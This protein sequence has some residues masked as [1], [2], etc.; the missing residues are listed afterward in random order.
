MVRG[1]GL[2]DIDEH[3]EGGETSSATSFSSIMSPLP[4]VIN[5]RQVNGGSDEAQRLRHAREHNSLAD[6]IAPVMESPSISPTTPHQGV[7]IQHGSIS[8]SAHHDAINT[9]ELSFEEEN[10]NHNSTRSSW[11]YQDHQHRMHRDDP[12]HLTPVH[13]EHL[14]ASHVERRRSV[15]ARH[16]P[17]G[18][19]ASLL[20]NSFFAFR[21][22]SSSVV[23]VV[24]ASACVVLHEVTSSMHHW[25][26]NLTDA[27][28][29]ARIVALSTLANA[30]LVVPAL[31]PSYCGLYRVSKARKVIRR[32]FLQ[33]CEI[34]VVGQLVVYIIQVL[35]WAFHMIQEPTCP[36]EVYASTNSV[37]R[38]IIY[39][40][41]WSIL[42]CGLLTW[43]QVTIFC[44]FRTHL[45]LQIGSA[46][47]SRHSAN[48]KGWLKRLFTLPSFGRRNRIIRQLRTD[49]FKAA[50]TG[51]LA[52]AES[53]LTR[54]EQLLGREFA[55]RKLYREP[56]LW[57]WSFATSRKNPLHVAVARGDCAMI[58]LFVKFRFDV[59]ALDKV[60]RVNFNFG[61]FFKWTRLLVK[62][63]DYLQGANEWVFLS[64][65]V[66]PLH[67][68]VQQGQ[69]DAVRTL[70]KHH[71]NVDTLPRASFYWPAAQ[72]NILTCRTAQSTLL[73]ENGSDV[74]LTP[75]HAAAAAN[76][77]VALDALLRLRHVDPDTL[78]EVVAGVHKRTALHWAAISGS[79][80]CAIRLLASRANPEA[81]D[82]DGRTPLHWAARNNHVQVVQVL[83]NQA[84]VNPNVQDNDGAPVLFFAAGAEGVGADVVSAL[85]EA[86]A[87]LAYT[88]M[89]GNTALHIALINENRTTAV[90][91]LRNG[92]DITATNRDGRRAVDCTTSTELQFAVKKEAGARDVMISYTHAHAPVAKGVRDFLVE[93]ARMTCWMDTMDPS[94]IGGGAVWREEIARGIFHAKVVV[95]VVC[96]GYSRS[97]WCLKE[98]AFARL[99]RTPGTLSQRNRLIILVVA[100]VLVVDPHGMSSDVERYVASEYILP[101]ESFDPTN[102]VLPDHV[103]AVIRQAIQTKH[104]PPP[105]LL[106]S[107]LP[108]LSPPPNSTTTSTRSFPNNQQQ[109]HRILSSPDAS[110]TP[111][112][113][114]PMV[115]VCYTTTSDSS[116]Q[117]QLLLR[118]TESLRRRGFVAR[119]AS[120][121]LATLDF[122][123]DV[124]AAWMDAASSVVV[125]LGRQ[126][127]QDMAGLKRLVTRA[128]RCKTA[129]VPVV[130]GGQFLDFS[131][132]YSLSRTSWF[133]FVDGIGFHASFSHLVNQLS[134]ELPHLALAVQDL[135]R[136]RGGHGHTFLRVYNDD[137]AE[138][139]SPSDRPIF[140]VDKLAMI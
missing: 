46:N 118:V 24:V 92:A 96:D 86:G 59:N 49:L 62:T 125:L 110:N 25:C 139:N 134:L 21:L 79:A 115:L 111:N 28:G 33:I 52:L 10:I 122:Q 94:G 3:D 40:K 31:L 83:L 41:L 89:D 68:A 60:A 32:P 57:L 43:W 99:A 44:L 95:A 48:L 51:D 26:T 67:V 8:S 23:L 34:I 30:I 70:L 74:A 78:G 85:V 129:V 103:L 121:S 58:N 6:S 75:L 15:K 106:S 119:L 19:F 140:N 27:T 135:P 4:V 127:H 71:A 82:R 65:L 132:L 120:T 66:P 50:L 20:R 102:P 53:L 124:D 112:D 1:T 35:L 100:V 13:S 137:D 16:A 81:S 108:P 9:N 90:S 87:D 5:P 77:A 98:L 39:V 104:I 97:E 36:A 136:S 114:I 72:R 54:A 64:V 45:K 38:A 101:F 123:D 88:D 17:D 84:K 126:W 107:S 63:Q 22:I 130:E 37:T 91:L 47:D 12:S 56:R 105:P 2:Q 73:E 61:L 18:S 109:Q 133:P 55:V 116:M 14:S 42:P 128:S 29:Y 138:T 80:A 117:Q 69:I 7:R 131:R 76:D 93:H 113:D 11:S